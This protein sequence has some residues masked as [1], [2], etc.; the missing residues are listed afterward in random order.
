MVYDKLSECVNGLTEEELSKIFGVKDHA[1]F[2]REFLRITSHIGVFGLMIRR[3]NDK[4]YLVA[5]TDK[6]PKDL[7]KPLA[8]TLSYIYKLFYSGYKVTLN[9]LQEYSKIP[10]EIL[11]KQIKSLTENKYIYKEKGFFRLTEKCKKTTLFDH[12]R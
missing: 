5:L 3:V 4:Y 9:I 8:L 2:N 1:N 12:R 10:K 6:P 7:P 11:K